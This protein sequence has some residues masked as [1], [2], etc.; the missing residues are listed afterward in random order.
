M[1]FRD[2]FFALLIIFP[3]AF[4][5]A[6][7]NKRDPQS[8]VRFPSSVLA[9]G[10]S[11][12]WRV[13]LLEKLPFLRFAAGV[14]MVL[15][16]MRPQALLENSP[17][18]KE[19]IDIVLALD[20]STS[21]LG[22][23]F[24]IKGRRQ[25]RV[26]VVKNVV[27]DFILARPNDRI[28]FVAFAAEAFSVCPLTLDHDWLLK[29]LS[30]IRGGMLPDGTAIGSALAVSLKRL[31]GS[32]AKSRI[33]VLLTDGRNNAGRISPETV[34]EAAR[35]LQARVY[36]IGVGSKGPVPYPFQDI[37]GNIVYR[38][39][40]IDLDEDLLARIAQMTGGRYFRATDTEALRKVYREIDRM[41]KVSFQEKGFRPYQELFGLFLI[42]ALL[43]LIAEAAIRSM[44]ARKV[45]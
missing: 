39:V 33:I 20:T 3:A 8:S 25:N 32:T 24:K 1:I 4:L 44:V 37:F 41:E 17:V 43:L 12:T 10:L 29:N 28:A 13:R 6:A 31:E 26:D 35:A 15:A 5:L 22:E 16:L 9:S 11:G 38:N 23:D 19:G 45:P 14:L 36:T 34:G 27:A 30:R 40:T 18:R 7:L 42:P 2:P 21:M